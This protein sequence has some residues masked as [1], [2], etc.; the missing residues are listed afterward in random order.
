[1]KPAK[2]RERPFVLEALVF[3]ERVRLLAQKGLKATRGPMGEAGELF[4]LLDAVCDAFDPE[5]R[6]ALG[7]GLSEPEQVKRPGSAGQVN[8]PGSSTLVGFSI[9]GK[10]GIRHNKN[11]LRREIAFSVEKPSTQYHRIPPSITKMLV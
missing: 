10:E 2:I 4:D 6:K 7:V 3:L 11:H 8:P 1:M 9:R 5:M